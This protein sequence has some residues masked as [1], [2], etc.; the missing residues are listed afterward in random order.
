MNE[1]HNLLQKW[2]VLREEKKQPYKE[3]PSDEE[4]AL[5]ELSE[6]LKKLPLQLKAEI[7]AGTSMTIKD[8]MTI[9][10]T[11]LTLANYCQL[12]NRFYFLRP[13]ISKIIEASKLDINDLYTMANLTASNPDPKSGIHL[14]TILDEIAGKVEKTLA[15]H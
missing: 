12:D 7:E 14:K 5:Q 8:S 9:S 13:F 3:D 4:Q 15:L 11:L 1:I 6:R 10:T 2:R